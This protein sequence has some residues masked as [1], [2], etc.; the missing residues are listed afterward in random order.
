MERPTLSVPGSGCMIFIDELQFTKEQILGMQRLRA[1]CLVHNGWPIAEPFDER[2]DTEVGGL[3]HFVRQEIHHRG[4]AADNE[5]GSL[6]LE[7]KAD[8]RQSPPVIRD[9]MTGDQYTLE[10]ARLVPELS[11][12]VERLEARIAEYHRHLQG[13]GQIA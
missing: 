6:Q 1:L 2:Y 3:I 9:Y 7:S 12:V 13:K 4:D 10:E 8:V 11:A 5:L